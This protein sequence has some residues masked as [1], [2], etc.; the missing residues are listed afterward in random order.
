MTIG[1]S[2][3]SHDGRWPLTTLPVIVAVAFP[4]HPSNLCRRCPGQYNAPFPERGHCTGRDSV[5]TGWTDVR[6]RQ[7]PRLPEAWLMAT[8]RHAN[9]TNPRWSFGVDM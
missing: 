9:A 4:E 7:Q 5:C 1:G 2:L 8:V 3:R 6:G